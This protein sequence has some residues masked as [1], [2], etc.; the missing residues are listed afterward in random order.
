M[1]VWAIKEGVSARIIECKGMAPGVLVSDEEIGL[2]LTTRI[3][4]VRHHL[5]NILHW[6]GPRPQFELW[7]SGVLSPEAQLRI[8]KTRNANSAKFDLIVVGPEELRKAAKSVGD[9]PLLKTLEHHFIP[10][11]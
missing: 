11:S 4:R 9:E 5:K 2:W 10:A 8:E 1:D 3:K 7:T 6:K